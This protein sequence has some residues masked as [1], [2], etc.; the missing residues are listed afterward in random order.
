MARKK[1]TRGKCVFCN[2]EMTKS[3]LTKHLKTCPQRKAAIDIA[4]KKPG[5]AE[6]LYHLQ[7][8]DAWGGDYWLHL[9]MKGSATLQHLDRYLRAI[10]LECC[11]HL[12]MFSIGGW[13]G[14]EI[15]KS[16]RIEQVF[17]PG[18]ELTHIYDFGSSSY[19]LIKA[20]DARKGMPLTRH[21][22]FLM[23]RNDPPEIVC[24]Q[25][26][27]PASWLCME[28]IIEL[29]EE[30]TLCDVHAKDH[31]HTAYGKPMLMVNS[32]RMGMCGY[33]GPAEPPY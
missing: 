31:P 25:C 5:K 32:P 17:E 2:R 21:A 23:A 13:S 9:E 4:D 27:E 11:G 29:N 22:I 20:L 12:S 14:D 28:C 10:W 3:G 33:T 8:Q 16:R 18:L 26:G 24:T 7:V 15:A 6:T 30:G 1:Q 19:T